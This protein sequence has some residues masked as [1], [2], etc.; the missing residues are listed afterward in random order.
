[1]ISHQYRRNILVINRHHAIMMHGVAQLALLCDGLMALRSFVCGLHQKAGIMPVGINHRLPCN[2]AD[3]HD[4]G[5]ID[6]ALILPQNDIT[7]MWFLQ[8]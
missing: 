3:Q 7:G 5:V 8:K 1:M 4:P 6:I 2:K